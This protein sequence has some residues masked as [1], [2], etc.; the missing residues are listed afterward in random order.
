MFF[1][2]LLVLFL[3]QNIV[4]ELF[5]Y[6]DQLAEGKLLSWAPLSPLGSW[7]NP[8]LAD[9]NG[10]SLMLCSQMPWLLLTPLIYSVLIRTVN[11]SKELAEG[12]TQ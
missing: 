1:L 10:R 12:N 8:V 3:S 6:H 7:F 4:V 11:S 9:F 5:L 2:A